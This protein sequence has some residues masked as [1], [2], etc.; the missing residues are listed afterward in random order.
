MPFKTKVFIGLCAIKKL[1]EKKWGNTAFHLGLGAIQELE[2]EV[3]DGK[4]VLIVNPE[5][6]QVERITAVTVLCLR[7][8]DQNDRIFAQVGKLVDGMALPWCKLPGTKCRG[9]ESAEGSLDRLLTQKLGLAMEDVLIEG[10][11][12]EVTYGNSERFQIRTR[13]VSMVHMATVQSTGN[14]ADW[15]VVKSDVLLNVEPY[16]RVD[17]FMVGEEL[18]AWLSVPEFE[19][20]S[21]DTLPWLHPTEERKQALASLFAE[22]PSARTRRSRTPSLV[23]TTGESSPRP[24]IAVV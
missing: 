21:F 12:E 17:V 2:A 15:D 23:R 22:L 16:R 20:F 7:H 8:P 3:E 4:A 10:H 6:G 11:E 24:E 9:D 5:S 1:S 19:Y 18:Y 14:L 13:Y